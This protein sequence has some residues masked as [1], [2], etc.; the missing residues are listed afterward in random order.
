MGDLIEF[1]TWPQHQHIFY[2]ITSSAVGFSVKGERHA[3]VGLAKRPGEKC[4]YWIVFGHDQ[5]WIEKDGARTTNVKNVSNILSRDVYTK[6]W[7]SWHGTRLQFG[8][9][10]T[11]VPLISRKIPVRDIQFVTFSVY[12]D[13]GT[14]QWKL[15]LP[16]KLQKPLLKKVRG[17]DL[18]WV[19]AE[20]QLPD[21]ALI[22]GYEKETLYIIKAPHRGSLTPGKFVPSQGLGF[23]PW[24]G[25]MH[26]KNKFEVLCGFN[27]I[28]VS[29]CSNR[30]P[31]GAVEGGY[32]EDS[33]ETLYIGRA[34]EDGNLIPGKVQ[35][36]HAVC[37]IPYNER[38]ISK[39]EYEILVN[40]QISM[41]SPN[42]YFVSHMDE[43]SENR[44]E[45][46]EENVYVDS[47]D[48][49]PSSESE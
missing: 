32:A 42:R 28:W 36:S 11:G 25:E 21:G 7:I 35:P 27:C 23:I 37:Y 26:E 9:T 34:V 6:F 49:A 48:Y 14:L 24:G 4:D 8:R 2:K 17:G 15:Y 45:E 38:E 12:A 30:I 5:C 41:H 19:V 29:T 22:G 20:D 3:A 1:T 39:K 44:Y 13:R 47:D 10:S 40:P 33:H 18:K 16:P 46:D 31:V 43:I